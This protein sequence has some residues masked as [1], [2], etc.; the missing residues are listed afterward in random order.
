MTQD[1][2]NSKVASNNHKVLLENDQVRVRDVWF[3][4][5]DKDGRHS[6]PDTMLY[7]IKGGKLKFTNP[8]GK[9]I[10]K[11]ANDGQVLWLDSKT[12]SPENVGDTDLHLLM[13]E[14]KTGSPKSAEENKAIVRH[15]IEELWNKRNKGVIDE[16][17][18]DNYINH[19][20][21]YPYKHVPGPEGVESFFALYG[22]AFPDLH[23]TI[24]DM[25]TQGDKVVWRWTASGTHKGYLMDIPPTNKPVTVTGIGIS[26][27]LSGKIIEDWVN[28]DTLGMMQQLGVIP[29]ME[30]D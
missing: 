13:V 17:I 24:E 25:I 9:I 8:E 29:Q 19:D 5:G 3:K 16:V 1:A 4:P 22:F 2:S 23:I 27:I 12:H 7:V 14:M 11:E 28:W 20:P 21:A 30:Q 6:H 26:R 15:F 10:I 18:D